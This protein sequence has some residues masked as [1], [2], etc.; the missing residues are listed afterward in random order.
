MTTG[1]INQVAAFIGLSIFGFLLQT[2]S[3]NTTT[4]A[5]EFLRLFLFAERSYSFLVGQNNRSCF[6]ALLNHSL[7]FG[8]TLKNIQPAIGVA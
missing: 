6:E 7:S 2:E 3:P 1:R 8:P 4:E 5:D